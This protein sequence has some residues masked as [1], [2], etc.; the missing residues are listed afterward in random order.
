[1]QGQDL[2]PALGLEVRRPSC[3]VIIVVCISIIIVSIICTS[4]LTMKIGQGTLVNTF[5]CQL[6]NI[7]IMFIAIS[8][9]QSIIIM[10][11]ISQS[12]CTAASQ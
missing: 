10:I 3:K 5:H 6:I 7:L 2:V 9:I 1:M 11:M 4:S 8:I 12:I